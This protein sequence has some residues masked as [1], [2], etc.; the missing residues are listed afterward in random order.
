MS[1]HIR[2]RGERSWELKYEAGTDA[3]TGK[4]QTRYLSFKGTKREAEAKLNELLAAV[5]KGSH[6]DPNKI[7]VA[8]FVQARIDQWEGSGTISA[9]SAERYRELHRN[10]ITPFL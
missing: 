7:T 5:A 10:Q 1:G 3:R 6:I 4:R 2:R 9:R 8:E